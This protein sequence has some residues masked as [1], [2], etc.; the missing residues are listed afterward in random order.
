MKISMFRL[1]LVSSFSFVNVCFGIFF[2][3]FVL[4]VHVQVC[5]TGKLYV[6]EFGI[7]I[8]PSPR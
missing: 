8:I 7:Q 4:G 6:M 3:T 1:S 2:T 5:Y